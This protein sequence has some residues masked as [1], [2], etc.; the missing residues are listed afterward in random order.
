MTSIDFYFNAADRLQVA[1]RLAGKAVAQKKKLLVFA[2]DA[3][4]AQ[5]LD[6]MMWTWP[7]T[8]FVPHCLAGDPLAADTP[9][10]IATEPDTAAAC[11]I[12]LNLAA[13]YPPKFERYERVL[14]IVSQENEERSAGRA[15]FKFYRDRGF[16]IASHDLAGER[17][18]E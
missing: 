13:E 7:A 10:L 9:V 2:P 15:R 17:A 4:L 12:L 6:R 8:G 1:C 16:A 3:G 11:D 5:K 14:E 18:G